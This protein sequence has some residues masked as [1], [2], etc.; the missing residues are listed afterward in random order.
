MTIP[1]IKIP[2]IGEYSADILNENGYKSAE[3]LAAANKDALCKVPGFGPVRA[4]LIIKAAQTLCDTMSKAADSFPV[5]PAAVKNNKKNPDDGD[6]S[7]EEKTD[8]SKKKSKKKKEK[9]NKKE[10]EQNK[11]Q[12]EKKTSAKKKKKKKKKK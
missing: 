2:G 6:I 12:D 4:Q 10:K 8:T 11:A 7:G 3:D 5:L 1:I 9:Q